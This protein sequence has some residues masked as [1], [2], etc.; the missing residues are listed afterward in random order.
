MKNIPVKT[1]RCVDGR[2]LVYYRSQVNADFWDTHWEKNLSKEMYTGAE[3]GHLGWFEETFTRYLPNDG[4]ILE[5]GCGLGKYLLA[6]RVRGYNAEGVDSGPE[7]VKTV[8]TLYPDLPIRVGDVTRLEV[9]NDYYSGYISLGVMEHCRKGPEPFLKEA[10]RVLEND[11][12]A[13][14]SVPCFHPLRRLKAYLGFYDGQTDGLDFYQY[15]YTKKEFSSLLH[16]AGFT[17]IDD[18]LYDGFK[19]VKDEIPLL[20]RIFQWRYIGWR[21]EKWLRS[22]EYVKRNLGHMILFTCR[23]D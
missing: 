2:R 15:A 9:P 19:G 20:L 12:V 13:L 16:A 8:Q 4:L 10:Y 23:K 21:L 7:T 3:R 11:G 5:A 17:I 18:M 6:L 22:S 1:A 14:I